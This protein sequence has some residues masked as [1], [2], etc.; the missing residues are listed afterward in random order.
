ME[1]ADVLSMS[2]TKLI[3][4][5]GWDGCRAAYCDKNAQMVRVNDAANAGP[6]IMLIK[7]NGHPHQLSIV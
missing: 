2:F 7:G 6:L 4:W 5:M 3:A 1:L